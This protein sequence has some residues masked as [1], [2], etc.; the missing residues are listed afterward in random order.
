[1]ICANKD[2][3]Y[4]GICS[5]STPP[6]CL[7][8]SRALYLLHSMMQETKEEGGAISRANS[9]AAAS[10]SYGQPYQDEDAHAS[11][12]AV[13]SQSLLGHQPL[14]EDAGNRVAPAWR[15]LAS[16]FNPLQLGTRRE[17]RRTV[18]EACFCEKSMGRRK[19]SRKCMRLVLG[20]LIVLYVLP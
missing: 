4:L 12:G 7:N 16:Q 2:E 11:S 3:R 9:K 14:C 10:T 17:T 13:D 1:M 18:N 19:G 20:A 5:L 15:R 6:F 8:R